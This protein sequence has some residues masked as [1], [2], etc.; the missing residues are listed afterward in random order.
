MSE[1]TEVREPVKWFAEQMEQQLKAN[2]HKGGWEGC[3]FYYLEKRLNEEVKE[4]V[5]ATKF[6]DVIREV[7][8]VANF[9]MMIADNARRLAEKAGES[10]E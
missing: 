3:T 9:A 7:T 10:S 8:D 2:D 6:E 1:Q 5:D 4:L